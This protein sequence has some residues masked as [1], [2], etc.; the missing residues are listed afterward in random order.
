MKVAVTGAAGYIGRHVVKELLKQGHQVVAADLHFKEVDERASMCSVD[1]FGRDADIYEKLE[2]PDLC[3]H[4][5]WRDGFIHQSALHMESLSDHFI[6]LKHMIDKGCPRIAV[7]GTMH[8]VGYWEG[9]I[10]AETPCRPLSQYGIAKYALGQA[11][12]QY[13][14]GRDTKIYWLRAYYITGDDARNCSVFTK[15]LRAAEDGRKTF[16]FN[17]GTNRYDFIDVR[18]LAK[19]IVA[20][21]MQDRYTGIINVCTGTPVALKDKAEEFIAKK[22]LP[23]QL[24]YGAFPDRAYDSPLIYGDATVIHEILKAGTNGGGKGKLWILFMYRIILKDGSGSA[25]IRC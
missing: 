16:P 3:I 25:L 2:K 15:L 10:D 18:E 7:M 20:S 12:M 11:L 4:L 23:I 1:L 8:E 9:K 24:Q 21:G 14:A 17:S 19:Q 5:A 22:H 13:A 6:F